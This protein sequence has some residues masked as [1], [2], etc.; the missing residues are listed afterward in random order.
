MDK[1]IKVLVITVVV[2]AVLFAFVPFLGLSLFSKMVVRL[3]IRYLVRYFT[4]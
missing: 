4:D 2:S 3:F 1:N